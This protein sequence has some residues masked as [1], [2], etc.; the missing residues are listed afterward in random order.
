VKARMN[1][2]EGGVGWCLV[3]GICWWGS[4]EIGDGLDVRNW[5]LAVRDEVRC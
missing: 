2:V 1:M 4:V 5:V 3:I